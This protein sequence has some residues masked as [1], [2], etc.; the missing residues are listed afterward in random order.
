LLVDRVSTADRVILTSELS[1]MMNGVVVFWGVISV[2]G[3]HGLSSLLSLSS[4]LPLCHCAV[5]TLLLGSH[6]AITVLLGV[7][8]LLTIGGRVAA[9]LAGIFLPIRTSRWV[10]LSI[11]ILSIIVGILLTVTPSRWV[12][13]AWVLL[14]LVLGTLAVLLIA[15][16]RHSLGELGLKYEVTS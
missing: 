1:G 11:L 6:R 5:D 3:R 14:A 10:L 2:L 4:L 8:V 13:L 12:L 16:L 15:V 9:C 7:E